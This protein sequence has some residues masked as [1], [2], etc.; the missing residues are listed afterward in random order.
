MTR[1][2]HFEQE[3]LFGTLSQPLCENQADRDAIADADRD[4]DMTDEEGAVTCKR[5]L[6]AL[7]Y[8]VPEAAPV[9]DLQ[10]KEL[11]DGSF[12]VAA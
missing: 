4:V 6:R 10:P 2:I 9:L 1:A 12:R 7:G 11:P 8:V 5:C 3:V